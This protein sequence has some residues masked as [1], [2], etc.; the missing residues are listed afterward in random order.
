MHINDLIKRALLL[1]FSPEKK[2]FRAQLVGGNIS[3]KVSPGGS[4]EGEFRSTSVL[5]GKTPVPLPEVPLKKRQLLLVYNNSG[6]TVY[7]GGVLVSVES[8]TPLKRDKFFP[9][10]DVSED[11]LVY[12]VADKGEN[13]L[14]AIEGS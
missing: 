10:L 14:R 11:V 5:V 3:V 2:A 1:G 9:Q 12:A 13:D 6:R 4:L 7:I 8:G